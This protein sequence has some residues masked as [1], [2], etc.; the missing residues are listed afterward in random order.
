MN[1]EKI[2]KRPRK[3]G[4]GRKKGSKSFTRMTFSE[5]SSICGSATVVPVS[6]VWLEQ[7]G[8]TIVTNESTEINQVKEEEKSEPSIQFKLHQ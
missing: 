5:L 6:R 4:S 3:A 8:V 7:M 1:D 2:T